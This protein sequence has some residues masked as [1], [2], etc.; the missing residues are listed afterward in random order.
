MAND[1]EHLCLIFDTINNAIRDLFIWINSKVIYMNEFF[2]VELLDRQIF[3][4]LS[5][6]HNVISLSRKAPIHT[7]TSSMCIKEYRML[8]L[9]PL[10]A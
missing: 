3:F 7:A 6:K 8:S 1:V 10:G 2:K 9:F 4:F 5:S